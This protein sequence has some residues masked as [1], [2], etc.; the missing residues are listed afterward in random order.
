MKRR[1][2]K[3][4]T[5]PFCIR[6]Y[7]ELIIGMNDENHMGHMPFDWSAVSHVLRWR[8]V[9]M[10]QYTIQAAVV[11]L[12]VLIVFLFMAMVATLP[13]V[14]LCGV[15]FS[16]CTGITMDL[17]FRVYCSH[18]RIASVLL[19]GMRRRVPATPV[20]CAS[21]AHVARQTLLAGRYGN[22]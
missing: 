9:G 21:Q 22:A 12:T 17:W 18:L 7:F 2:T 1:N 16:A 5:W 6:A 14:F 4:I 13:P 19:H 3:I 11:P 10:V 20:A 15:C 8:V